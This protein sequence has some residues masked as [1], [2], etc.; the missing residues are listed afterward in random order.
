[1]SLFQFNEFELLLFFTVLIRYSVL[2]AILPFVGDRSVP[3]P[4]KVLLALAVSLAIFPGLL[5]GGIIKVSDAQRWAHSA[6]AMIGVIGSEVMFAL[7]IGFVARFSFEAISFGG[8][9]IGNFMGLASA[10]SYDAHQE[11]QS[12]IIAQIQSTLAM[13]IFLAVDA[14]HVMLRASLESYAHVGIGVWNGTPGGLGQRLIEITGQV[15]VF[16]VQLAAP[17]ALAMFAVNVAFGVMARAMPQ[18][19]ILVLSFAVSGIVGLAI[20]FLSMSEFSST[21][22]EIFLRGFEWMAGVMRLTAKGA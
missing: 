20:L 10:S 21:A 14:H 3:G 9:L 5:K 18:L 7:L 15:I 19:N 8:N 12:Q 16:G 2:F 1:M 6:P 4:T 22:Q 11:S 13:L 17:V